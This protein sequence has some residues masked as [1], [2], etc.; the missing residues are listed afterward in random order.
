MT[1]PRWPLR[2]QMASATRNVRTKINL[3]D[4]R[5][6]HN[7]WFSTISFNP[8]LSLWMFPPVY[9]TRT[10]YKFCEDREPNALVRRLFSL[11]NFF[12]SNGLLLFWKY[13]EG[14]RGVLSV[15]V[16]WLDQQ[17]LCCSTAADY[18]SSTFFCG[19]EEITIVRQVCI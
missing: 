3:H 17:T 18:C 6:R 5:S 12:D 7:E 11:A 16:F 15:A 9:N 1:T 13:H 2:S 4:H 14:E 10:V 19:Q 8:P